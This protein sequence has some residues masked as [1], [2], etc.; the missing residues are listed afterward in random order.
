MI[1]YPI[2]PAAWWLYDDIVLVEKH[3]VQGARVGFVENLRS[4]AVIPL[5]VL[6]QLGNAGMGIYPADCR[7]FRALVP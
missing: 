2:V 3:D 1:P 7:K 4:E 6:F 5:M